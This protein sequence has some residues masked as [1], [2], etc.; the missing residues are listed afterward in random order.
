M[1]RLEFWFKVII[2]ELNCLDGKISHV[3]KNNE[4][5]LGEYTLLHTLYIYMIIYIYYTYDR[6]SQ[7][8]DMTIPL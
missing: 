7:E 4:L 2:E 8:T 3:E 5:F 1:I 6:F